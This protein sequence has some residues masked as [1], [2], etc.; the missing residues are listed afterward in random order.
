LIELSVII[1]NYNVCHFLKLCLQSVEKSSRNLAVEIIVVDNNSSDG[2]CEM[3]LRDY[4]EITLIQNK[5]NLGFAKA[6][7]QGVAKANGKYVLIL[8]PD[9]FVTEN[10]F[11]KIIAFA[12]EKVN[13]GAIGVQLIDGTGT[14]LPESKRKIPTPKVALNKFISRK[15][16]KSLYYFSQ[17]NSDENGEVDILVGAFMLVK[18][19]T[20]L[21]VGMFDEDY[22]MYGEDIDLS[23]KFLKNG[24][25]NYY[26]G[27]TKVVHFK[28]ESTRKDLKY[29]KYFYGAM[30][31]FYKKHLK[32]SWI[33]NKL[34]IIG[35]YTWYV[36]K[37]FE[38]KFSKNKISSPKRIAYFGD[39]KLHFNVIKKQFA[40]L[41]VSR[42]IDNSLNQPIDLLF[43]DIENI[44]F[45]NIIRIMVSLKKYHTKFRFIAAQSNYAIG[46]DS[47]ND[48]G[49]LLK[50][51]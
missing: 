32:K 38:L 14:F 9:T 8:N 37:F 45:K 47:S 10:T 44:S 50:L 24:Y 21:K 41:N 31:I 23:Y 22:F 35:I 51:N 1:V 27:K 25:K 39:N 20:Y 34:M 15:R 30:H 49:Y 40:N 36:F 28:G 13:V 11:D 4:P 6:N 43:I 17:L 18:K 12:K 2:S 7:N 16:H 26:F 42:F 5:K 3:I 19:D 33:S 48:K 29:L 46:S